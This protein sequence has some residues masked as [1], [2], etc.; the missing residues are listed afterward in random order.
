MKNIGFLVGEKIANLTQ[1]LVVSAI[2]G[3]FLK[4]HTELSTDFVDCPRK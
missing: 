4:F 1:G 3:W 2:E